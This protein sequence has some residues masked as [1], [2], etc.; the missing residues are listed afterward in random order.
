MFNLISS[1]TKSAVKK[2][3]FKRS[4]AQSL[5]KHSHSTLG[6]GDLANAVKLPKDEQLNEWLAVHVVDFYNCASLIFGQ[7]NGC[8]DLNCPKMTA[9]KLFDFLYRCDLDPKT[10]KKDKKQKPEDLSAPQYI[11]RSFDWMQEL[12]D[13]EAMFPTNSEVPFPKNFQKVVKAI[14]KKLLR[15][16][17]HL[18]YDHFKQITALGLEAHVNSSLK[19]F[20]YFVIEFNLL[21]KAD[22]EPLEDFTKNRLGVEYW[23]KIKK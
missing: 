2:K 4:T 1:G 13:N 23:N 9:G 12:L 6:N 19:H 10:G 17:A 20:L 16:Y 14:F 3:D 15:I 21:K 7:L 18:V 11:K 5:H 22:L 8:T